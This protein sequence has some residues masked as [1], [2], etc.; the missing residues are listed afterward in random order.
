MNNTVERDETFRATAAATLA[1]VT[2]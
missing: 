2:T 1:A